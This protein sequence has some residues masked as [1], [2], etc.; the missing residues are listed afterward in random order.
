M[1]QN[2][3]EYYLR[4]ADG[5][6][7]VF[8]A[9]NQLAFVKDYPSSYASRFAVV[10]KKCNVYGLSVDGKFISRDQQTLKFNLANADS[11]RSQ[12]TVTSADGSAADSQAGGPYFLQADANGYLTY[13]STAAGDQL[14]LSTT[15]TPASQF[16]FVEVQGECGLLKNGQAYWIMNSDGFVVYDPVKKLAYA[17]RVPPT[18]ATKFIAV[19]KDCDLYGFQAPDGY[20]LSRCFQCSSDLGDPLTVTMHTRDT[21]FAY[22]QWRLSVF[23]GDGG[24]FLIR[25]EGSEGFIVPGITANGDRQLT[26]SSNVYP[27]TRF[28]IVDAV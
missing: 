20:C 23:G 21:N 7:V 15:L 5:R 8:D 18:E 13:K 2:G 17:K 19:Q 28:A 12:W 3:K 11:V 4:S 16:S 10:Q 26:L 6:Y 24:A 22:N 1:L 25:G 9:N 27:N 14:S